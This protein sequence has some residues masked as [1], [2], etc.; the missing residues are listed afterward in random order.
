MDHNHANCNLREIKIPKGKF[1]GN[2]FYF[3]CSWCEDHQV[4]VCRCGWE[5]GHHFNTNSRNLDK[6]TYP[7]HINQHRGLSEEE[8][9]K[10]LENKCI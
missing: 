10:L 7:E 3:S 1:K 2:D 6:S 4:E 8:C 5:F 9:K